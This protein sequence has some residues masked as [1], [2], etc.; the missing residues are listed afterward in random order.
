MN[1]ANIY[2]IIISIFITYHEINS[3]ATISVVPSELG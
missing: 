2:D 3:I 1:D